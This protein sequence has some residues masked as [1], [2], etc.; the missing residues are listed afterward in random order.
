MTRPDN[1]LADAM[2]GRL[3]KALAEERWDELEVAHA[4]HDV[5]PDLGRK[6]FERFARRL[7]EAVRAVRPDLRHVPLEHERANAALSWRAER[8]RPKIDVCL[9]FDRSGLCEGTFGIRAR[10]ATVGAAVHVALDVA[11]HEAHATGT[12]RR[13]TAPESNEEW[14]PIYSG[15]YPLPSVRTVAGIREMADH[16][17]SSLCAEL[18]ADLCA[19]AGIVDAC[20]EALANP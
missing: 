2:R 8:W 13:L 9:Q 17:A 6:T 18:A 16:G 5:W 14:W 19:L 7:D 11:G 10:R 12:F 3:G 15:R 1:T 20:P 4:V